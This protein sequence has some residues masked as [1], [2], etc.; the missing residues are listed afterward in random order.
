MKPS[1]T[2]DE[3]NLQAEPLKMTATRRKTT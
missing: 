3:R 2:T 1:L